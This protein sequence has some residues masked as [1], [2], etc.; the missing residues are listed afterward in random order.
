MLLLLDFLG[1]ILNLNL[2][3]FSQVRVTHKNLHLQ[4][5]VTVGVTEVVVTTG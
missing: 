3:F 2:L 5:A 1:V 4:S